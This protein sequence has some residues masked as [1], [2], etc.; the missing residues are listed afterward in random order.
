MLPLR[1]LTVRVSDAAVE[2][3]PILSDDVAVT[4][5]SDNPSVVG[6]KI[7]VFVN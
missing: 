3:T 5:T 7:K 2:G 6:A 1:D 4:L